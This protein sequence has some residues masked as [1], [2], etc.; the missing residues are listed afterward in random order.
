VG[1]LENILGP[2]FVAYLY[3]NYGYTSVFVYI[4][5]AWIVVALTV[6]IFGPRT[7]QRSVG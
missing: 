1:R 7:S 4:A 6:G 2:L 5:T 3:T